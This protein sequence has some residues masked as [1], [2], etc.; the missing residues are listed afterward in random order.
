MSDIRQVTRWQASA[1][2]S[3]AYERAL[4]A[5]GTEEFGATIRDSVQS[6][7]GGAR[8]LYLF[9]AT[10]AQEASL[11]YYYGEPGLVDLF[12]AYRKWYLRIDPV[13][14]AYRAAPRQN[15]VVVQRVRRIFDDAGIVERLSIIQRGADAWRVMSVSRHAS[16]GCFVDT[17]IETLI[18]IA[19]MVLPMLP[20]NRQQTFNAER[21]CAQKLE[22]R[23]ATRFGA[24][25]VRE[26]EVCARAVLGMSVEVT[27]R[28]LGI[29]PTSVL[30]YRHRAYQ[31]L[32][33]RSSVQLCAL[34][35][36]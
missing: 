4:C 11:Q 23:F 27:A 2:T 28:D 9:E 10:G 34:V 3:L 35:T 21:P 32:G 5:I 36:H 30:T 14:D 1:S 24:L 26:R 20:L 17:E 33:V 13:A 22:E 19:C 18:G 7:V 31:K 8:R 25:T 12:P 6:A 29:A 15:N 16:D